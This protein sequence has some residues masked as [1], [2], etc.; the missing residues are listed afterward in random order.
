MSLLAV[1]PWRGPPVEADNRI[2]PVERKIRFVGRAHGKRGRGDRAT[3]DVA[4]AE[5]E[6][7]AEEACRLPRLCR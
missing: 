6:S 4:V 3:A 5:L 1:T 2:V 7:T